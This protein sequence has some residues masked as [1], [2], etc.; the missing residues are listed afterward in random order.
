[1]KCDVVDTTHYWFSLDGIYCRAVKA[2]FENLRHEDI[3]GGWIAIEDR[4]W[5]FPTMIMPENCYLYNQL[6]VEE[7]R[8]K[9]KKDAEKDMTAF[10]LVRDVDFTEFCND[11]FGDG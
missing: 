1:M 11:I 5:G 7:K 10:P 8:F 4:F 6:A 3:G 2:R 9:R